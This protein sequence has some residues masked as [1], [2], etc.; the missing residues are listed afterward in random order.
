MET[1]HLSGI[2]PAQLYS[3]ADYQS[4]NLSNINLS[5]NNLTGVNLVGQNL[6]D[7]N[8]SSAI[9][10]GGNLTG[11]DFSGANLSSTT[12]TGAEIR[13]AIFARVFVSGSSGCGGKPAY[14]SCWAGGTPGV[15]NGSGIWFARILFHSQLSALDL[16]QDRPG[17]EWCKAHD[18]AGQ[19]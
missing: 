3:T 13:G 16:S 15:T 6:A 1:L 17:L 12:F 14:D 10:A 4:H 8:L 7:A 11:A 2:T 19:I 5:G 9:L 18:L